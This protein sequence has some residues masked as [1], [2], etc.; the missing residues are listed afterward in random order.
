[1]NNAEMDPFIEGGRYAKP[2]NTELPPEDGYDYETLMKY[3]NDKEYQ[4]SPQIVE[5]TQTGF[6]SNGDYHVQKIH[7]EMPYR[8]ASEINQFVIRQVEMSD[9]DVGRI[10]RDEIASAY[11]LHLID[12]N[13]FT[14]DMM[15]FEA[16]QIWRTQYGR[17][18]RG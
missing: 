15:G 11:L 8:V 9:Y 16:L 10:E 1:M 6:D 5:D 13:A 4:P 2:E 14:D 7:Q 12:Q 3:L 18:L 17:D